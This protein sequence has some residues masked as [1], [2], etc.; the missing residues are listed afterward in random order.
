L[1]DLRAKES[2][3][4][5]L[6]E[7]ERDTQS[8]MQEEA[9]ERIEHLRAERRQESQDNANNRADDDDDHDVEVEYVP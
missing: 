2:E 8:R 3:N 5:E 7:V 4:P 1:D 6:R 9:R